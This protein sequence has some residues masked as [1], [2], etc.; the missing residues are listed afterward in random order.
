MERVDR[1]SDLTIVCVLVGCFHSF[2]PWGSAF[3]CVPLSLALYSV[4]SDWLL[5]TSVPR[6]ISPFAI[7]SATIVSVFLLSKY[8]RNTGRFLLFI[9]FSF[10]FSF[11]L[12]PTLASHG[13]MLALSLFPRPVKVKRW[14]GRRKDRKK[15]GGREREP[16]KCNRCTVQCS[17]HWRLCTGSKAPPLVT[18]HKSSAATPPRCLKHCDALS[19]WRNMRWKGTRPA[20][21]TMAEQ[22]APTVTRALTPTGAKCELA[23]IKEVVMRMPLT[24]FVDTA[25]LMKSNVEKN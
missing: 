24:R 6:L 14:E 23:M 11:S 2:T 21:H 12:S 20:R 7:S 10:S 13:S 8:R 17:S 25:E 1:L 16:G 4:L 15:V 22:K 19:L 3:F 18:C 9:T 5:L